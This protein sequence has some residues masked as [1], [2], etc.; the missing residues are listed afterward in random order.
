M[1]DRI[2][3]HDRVERSSLQFDIEEVGVQERGRRDVLA[4]SRELAGGNVDT[5]EIMAGADDRSRRR[6]PGAAAEL[7]DSAFWAQLSEQ[8]LN[9]LVA[10]VGS[11]DRGVGR[12]LGRDRVVALL[13]ELG[14]IV[15][16]GLKG[17]RHRHDTPRS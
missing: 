6:N 16:G 2:Q 9:P 12:I 14:D 15:V 11:G 13:H 5:N 7:E 3:R 1:G 8:P 4:G 17:G 10:R